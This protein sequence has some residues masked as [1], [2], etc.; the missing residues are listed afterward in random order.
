MKI[1]KIA[2][3]SVP[4]GCIE[5]EFVLEPDGTLRQTIVGHGDGASCMSEDDKRLLNDLL[6]Q[7]FG[8]MLEVEEAGKTK[9]F[10][11]E[12]KN[13]APKRKVKT[14]PFGEDEPS[15]KTK[16]KEKIGLGFGV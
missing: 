15:I 11:D 12:Q 9:E 16:Q 6:R 13:K 5:V 14:A 2:S 8:D 7:E 4:Q 10:Y 3:G 1:I